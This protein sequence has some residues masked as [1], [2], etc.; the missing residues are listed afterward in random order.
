MSQRVMQTRKS[1]VVPLLSP[2]KLLA[3]D[4]DTTN[5]TSTRLALGDRT[6]TS[7]ARVFDDWRPTCEALRR[8]RA[9]ED[10]EDDYNPPSSSPTQCGSAEISL[11]ISFIEPVAPVPVKRKRARN[12]C[13]QRL[14]RDSLSAL[15]APTSLPSMYWC[16]VATVY[17]LMFVSFY[18]SRRAACS[19]PSSLLIAPMCTILSILLP[20][21]LS[22]APTVMVSRSDY[23]MIPHR[24]TFWQARN[25]DKTR[26]L[27]L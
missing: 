25:P 8:K 1:L 2:R 18:Q 7:S 3:M 22:T 4:R 24:P 15:C 16:I 14:I 12:A 26:Y 10:S 21:L 11:E 5:T 13:S 27:P 9:R 6:N 23:W 19:R 20:A 17:S